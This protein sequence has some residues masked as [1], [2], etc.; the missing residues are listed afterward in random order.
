MPT[1]DWIWASTF[2]WFMEPSPNPRT[3]SSWRFWTRVFLWAPIV[4]LVITP[5]NFALVIIFIVGMF[6]YDALFRF[7]IL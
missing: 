2:I 3:V 7:R 6:I 1:F 5:I 4:W